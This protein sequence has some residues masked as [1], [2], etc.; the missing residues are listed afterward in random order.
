[1]KE[2][3]IGILLSLSTFVSIHAVAQTTTTP[4]PAATAPATTGMGHMMGGMMH[5]GMK[6]GVDNTPGWSMMSR[7]EHKAYRDKMHGIKTY[8]ECSAYHDEH[9][10]QMEARAKEKGKTLKPTEMKPCGMRFGADNTPGWSMMSHAE[11]KAHHDK[12]HSMQTLG[13]CNAY[14]DEHM[15][16]MEARAKE[17]GKTLKPTEIKPC[18]IMKEYGM[19]K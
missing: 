11:H 13:A 2:L 6:F 17:K 10:K 7:A 16:Q 19:V 14:H 18:D 1:M 3:C 9:M 5:H 12:M 4:P 15:K 8:G